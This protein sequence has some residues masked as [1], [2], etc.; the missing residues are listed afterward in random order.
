MWD[1]VTRLITLF[2]C[3]ATILRS[4]LR[5]HLRVSVDT[6]PALFALISL[7]DRN[8]FVCRRM[9][10]WEKIIICWFWLAE[11]SGAIVDK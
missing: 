7:G 5:L 10:W 2:S 8:S 9:G 3:F 1:K 6:I 4:H 11:R